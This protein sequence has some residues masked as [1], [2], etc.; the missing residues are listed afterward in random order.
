MPTAVRLAAAGEASN[1]WN[2]DAGVPL[3][4]KT[5]ILFPNYLEGYRGAGLEVSICDGC[6][7]W[8]AL[9]RQRSLLVTS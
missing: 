7:G 9:A 4:L 2:K 1:D 8:P 5:A 6:I 3:Y